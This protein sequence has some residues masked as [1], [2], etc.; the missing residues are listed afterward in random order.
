MTPEQIEA[1]MNFL[2]TLTA[3]NTA[4]IVIHFAWHASRQ[5]GQ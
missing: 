3:I 5:E 1:G 2:A 4:I